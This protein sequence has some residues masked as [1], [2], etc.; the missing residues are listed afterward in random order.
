MLLKLAQRVSTRIPTRRPNKP[1]NRHGSR[2]SHNTDTYYLVLAMCSCPASSGRAISAMFYL[3][4][5]T[6]VPYFGSNLGNIR[7]GYDRFGF[8]RRFSLSLHTD[9]SLVPQAT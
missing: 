1:T 9:S 6:R 2:V 3:Q 5:T 7:V 8:I 4:P